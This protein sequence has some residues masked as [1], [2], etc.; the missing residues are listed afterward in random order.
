MLLQNENGAKYLLNSMELMNTIV[1]LSKL[2]YVHTCIMYIA[3][4]II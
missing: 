1:G 2:K 4:Y 3:V